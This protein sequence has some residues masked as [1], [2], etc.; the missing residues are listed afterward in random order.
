LDVIKKNWVESCSPCVGCL[1]L[2]GGVFGPGPV[3]SHLIHSLV[4][5]SLCDNLTTTDKTSS[6][7]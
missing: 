4:M 2:G 6:E 3:A 7:Q 1:G 5:R